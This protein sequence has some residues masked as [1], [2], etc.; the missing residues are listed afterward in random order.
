MKCN[1]ALSRD[2]QEESTYW[3]EFFLP[4]NR[5]S[6]VITL[7]IL[8]QVYPIYMGECQDKWRSMIANL[9]IDLLELKEER[10]YSLISVEVEKLDN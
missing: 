2:K 6:S 5:F 10:G 3:L 9:I 1:H 4:R 7:L 8:E